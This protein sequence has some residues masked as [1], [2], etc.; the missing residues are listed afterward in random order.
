MTATR[1]RRRKERSPNKNKSWARRLAVGIVRVLLGLVIISFL[2]VLT[3]RWI[4]PPTSMMMTIQRCEAVVNHRKDFRIDYRW[5]NWEQI[6][7]HLPLAIIASEDQKF[8]NHHGFDLEAITD[9]VKTRMN[10]G[11][12][13]GASTI[14]QQVAKNLFLWPG[15]S[16][17]R[18]GIEAYFTALIEIFWSKRRVLEVYMNIA[19]FGDGIFGVEA[20]CQRYFGKPAGNIHLWEAARL[21]AVLPG[22]KTMN[23]KHPSAYVYKRAQWIQRQIDQMGGE[24]V[25]DKIK[26]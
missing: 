25:L 14:T 12:L 26:S 22:P 10:G 8:T 17:S 6:A 9:A 21:A 7:K 20:A 11:R 13:R 24:Q 1:K 16:L 3:L 4:N 19:E 23:P 15:K 5:V 18:K 2:L